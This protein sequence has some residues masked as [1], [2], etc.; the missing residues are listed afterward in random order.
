MNGVVSQS[1]SGGFHVIS[2]QNR[3]WKKINYLSIA[4]YDATKDEENEKASQYATAA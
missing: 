1:R 4:S 3:I 2:P